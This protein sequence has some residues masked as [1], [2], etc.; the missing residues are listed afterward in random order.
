[1]QIETVTPQGAFIS[2]TAV[3]AVNVQLLSLGSGSVAASPP[4]VLADG[5]AHTSQIVVSNLVES[6]GTTPVPNGAKVGL[7]VVS[8][9]ALTPQGSCI[10]SAGGAVGSAGTSPG[11]GTTATNNSNFAVF[12]V[13]GGKVQAVYSDFGLT[14]SV[15]QTQ[16]ATVAVVPVDPNGNVITRTSYATGAVQLPGT[17][18]ATASGPSSISLSGGG[19]AS[20]T[21]SGIKDAAGN[22]V[23]DGTNVAVTVASCATL[24]PSGSCNNSTGGTIVDGTVS[25]SDSRF[26]V[27]TVQGGSITITYS[28][29]GASSGT[30]T[31]QV[32]P[33][34]PNG[35]K[36][37]NASLF[38]GTWAITVTN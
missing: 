2:R 6:D 9:A 16:T 4:S 13:A 22:T 23:P 5:A 37:G 34:Q 20:V 38:G 21:F 8:C 19:T 31:I 3:A 28:P 29:A 26:K 17:T 1:V 36:I 32:A 18:S 14:S 7:A 11:D 24:T 15:N 27:F 10:N 30:A 12:T 25:P 35:T 33:A